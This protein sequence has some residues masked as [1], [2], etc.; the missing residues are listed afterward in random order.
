MAPKQQKNITP[1]TPGPLARKTRQGAENV[2]RAVWPYLAAFVLAIIVAVATG[3]SWVLALVLGAAGCHAV[4]RLHEAGSW[5]RRGGKAAARKRRKYQGPAS[6]R[7][8]RAKLSLSAVR[9]RAHITRP[10]T[11]RPHKLPAEELGVLLGTTV[12]RTR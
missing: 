4:L 7:E 12:R 6:R 2:F 9:R 1:K 10:A 5:H 11:G 8:I 3:Q